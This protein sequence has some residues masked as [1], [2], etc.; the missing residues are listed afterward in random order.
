MPQTPDILKQIIET[1]HQEVT[2]RRQRVSESNLIALARQ[3]EPPRGFYQALQRYVSKKRPAV[4]AE[5]KKA[6]PSQGV[7]REHFNPVEIAREFS[8]SGAA[9]LS[10]LT[11]KDYFQ[12][13]EVY[14]QMARDNSPLPALRKDFMIDPYQI[15]E[16]RALGADCVLL[17]AAALSDQQMQELN[18]TAQE[19]GM[20][21]LIE[22]HDARELER[23]MS[24]QP[25]M[26]GINNRDLHTFDVSLQT[27]LTLRTLL[28]DDLLIVTESGIQNSQDVQMMF[29]QGI[30][31]FLTGESLMR[32]ASPGQKMRELFL[33]DRAT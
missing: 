16:S 26:L 10:I 21:V 1:K 28:P 20:D 24:L 8:V 33:L 30:Y 4:I 32:A 29:D 7:I 25:P 15:L 13:A 11:D 18:A 12:G 5:I 23:A 22:V 9:C 6:S 31:A 19:W 2:S 14:L 3:A 17:I 27:T